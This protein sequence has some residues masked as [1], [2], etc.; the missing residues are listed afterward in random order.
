MMA[1]LYYMLAIGF[2]SFACL[3]MVIWFLLK[4]VM[5]IPI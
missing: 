5:G 4:V 3:D 2:V 1:P